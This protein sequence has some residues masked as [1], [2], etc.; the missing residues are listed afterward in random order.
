MKSE[1]RSI[2]F[3]I[4]NNTFRGLSDESKRKHMSLNTLVSQILQEH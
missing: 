3:R 1:N 4:G 2:T